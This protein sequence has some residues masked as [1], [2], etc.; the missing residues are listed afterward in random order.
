MDLMYDLP[1]INQDLKEIV[2]NKEV[3]LDQAKPVFVYAKDEQSA[4]SF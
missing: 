4:G 3:V 1:T 2:I